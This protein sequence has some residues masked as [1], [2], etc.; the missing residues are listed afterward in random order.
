MCQ[1]LARRRGRRD[2]RALPPGCTPSS[3]PQTSWRYERPKDLQ[4]HPAP[5]VVQRAE[6]IHARKWLKA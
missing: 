1:G 5:H 4:S 3:W 2:G 6:Q